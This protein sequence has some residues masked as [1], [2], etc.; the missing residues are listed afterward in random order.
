MQTNEV[1]VQ[2]EKSLIKASVRSEIKDRIA[3]YNW[4]TGSMMYPSKR[5]NALIESWCRTFSY[6]ECVRV[7]EAEGLGK[8][9]Q[10]TVKRWLAKE[11][12]SEWK[13]RRLEEKAKAEGYTRDHWKAQGVDIEEGKKVGAFQFMAWKEMGKACGY[14]EGGV[15]INNN[16]QINFQERA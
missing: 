6:A 16:V 9:S 2:S 7:L 14:Y 11:H 8:I 1:V 3:Q 15:G 5:E 4:K 10:Q 13:N 12:V